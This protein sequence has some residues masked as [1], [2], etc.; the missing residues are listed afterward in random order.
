MKNNKN[1][2]QQI[3]DES[4][5]VVTRKGFIFSKKGYNKKVIEKIRSDLTVCPESQEDTTKSKK[6]TYYAK[7]TPFKIYKE[8]NDLF[9]VPKFYGFQEV[10]EKL[11]IIDIKRGDKIDVSWNSKFGL[12]EHQKEP[13]QKAIEAF[14]KKAGGGGILKL[15]CGEG[16]TCIA[17]YL[18]SRIKRKTIII[19]NT[20]GLTTQ[21]EEE[22]YK[23]LGKTVRVGFIKG[24]VLDII[25]KDIVIA[26]INSVAMVDYPEEFFDSFDMIVCDEIHNYGARLFSQVFKKI[27]V[28]YTLGLSATPNRADGCETAFLNYIGPIL[29]ENFQKESLQDVIVNVIHYKIKSEFTEEVRNSMDSPNCTTMVSNISNNISRT[30]MVIKCIQELL[31]KNDEYNILVLSQRRDQLKYMKEKLDELEIPCGLYIGQM[32][33]QDLKK[34]LTKKVILGIYNL[35]SEGFNHTPLNVAIM[36]SPKKHNEITNKFSQI[37]GRIIRIHHKV[38]PM[39]ID[40]NDNFSIFKNQYYSRKKYY[41]KQDNYVLNNITINN[42][43]D[44][45]IKLK[46]IQYECK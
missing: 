25:D 16:K 30:N 45:N 43:D 9:Y 6:K 34:T 28:K 18:I 38:N 8:S 1:L 21:W 15:G 46:E 13:V 7:G 12:R 3:K 40:I 2:Y 11:D 24:G 36:I 42:E 26:V 4:L 17:L 31:N 19:V 33:E 35:V 27:Q 37:T 32:K 29:Y 14:N 23:F 10:S 39:I 41:N 20:V 44:V 22:I 5:Y